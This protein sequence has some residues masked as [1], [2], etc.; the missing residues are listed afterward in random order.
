MTKVTKKVRTLRRR[1]RNHTLDAL[2]NMIE[3]AKR[4]PETDREQ[5]SRLFTLLRE[6]NKE[7]REAWPT[8]SYLGIKM[9]GPGSH[10]VGN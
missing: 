3:L 4:D 1:V 2:V 9:L 7:C 8:P 10:T 6:A 5:L